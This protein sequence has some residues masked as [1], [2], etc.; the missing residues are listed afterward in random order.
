LSKSPPQWGLVAY[1][2]FKNGQQ[3]VNDLANQ[4]MNQ[5]SDRT[6]QHLESYTDLPQKVA[7]V[8]AD[9]LELGKI[10]LDSQN[11]QGL[12]AYF[13]KRIET[14]NSVSF[15]YTGNEQGKFIGAGP[16][17]RDG[18]LSY[19]IEVTDGTTNGSY[20]SYATDNQGNRTKN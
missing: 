16:V 9:D 13:L 5:V 4:L 7:Q 1:F 20:V 14:F 19:I 11:L 3:A 12:D 6:G 15:I 8:V 10:N 2:S 17:R 18:T